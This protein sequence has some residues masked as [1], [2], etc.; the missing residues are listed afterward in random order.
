MN[1]YIIF[2]D[3]TIY[4]AGFTQEDC[5]KDAKQW[6]DKEAY[7]PQDL[8]RYDGEVKEA[9]THNNLIMIEAT[10][11]LVEYVL[12]NGAPDDWHIVDAVGY[13]GEEDE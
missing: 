10:K 1:G 2:A 9:V 11:D 8:T 7:I 13:L 6:L 12:D 3:A 4:G 5:K